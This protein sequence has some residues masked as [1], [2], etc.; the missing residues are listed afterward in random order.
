MWRKSVMTRQLIECVPNFS[1]GRRDEVIEEIVR[2]FREGKDCDLLDYRA[3]RDHNRLV[4]SIVGGP[5]AIQEALLAAAKVAISR[6][7]LEYHQGSHPRIGAVDVI[8]FVP[9]HDITM[10][11]CVELARGFARRYYQE[12]GVPVYLYEE[13]AVKPERTNLEVIR[14]GQYEALKKEVIN[15]TPLQGLRLSERGDFLSPLT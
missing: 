2:T 1:E 13:A 3:D 7:D 11:A 8:P 4:V 12:T 15:Y 5:E 10:E 9:L 6:I 14:R